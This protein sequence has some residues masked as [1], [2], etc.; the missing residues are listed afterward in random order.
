MLFSLAWRC[1]DKTTPA[2]Q[3]FL[4]NMTQKRQ[5][6]FA[7]FSFVIFYIQVKKPAAWQKNHLHT[8]KNPR[9]ILKRGFAF[10]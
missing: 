6:K 10:L 9:C 8:I 4:F 1:L 7:K 2:R 3:H 5:K